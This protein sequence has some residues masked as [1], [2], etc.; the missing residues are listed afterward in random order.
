MRE[1][2]QNPYFVCLMLLGLAWLFVSLAS[3]STS[4]LYPYCFGSDSAQFQT[5]GKAWAASVLPYQGLFDH[6]GPLIFLI[7]ALGYALSGNKYGVYFL[8]ILFFA[9]TLHG[10]FL[11][12]SSVMPERRWRIPYAL[13][14]SLLLCIKYLSI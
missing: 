10:L 14:L 7:N 5:I 8:Q 1:G 12:A 3:Y 11:L 9:M 4:P 2:T 6:K 13:V